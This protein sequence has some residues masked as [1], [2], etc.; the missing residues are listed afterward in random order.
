MSKSAYGYELVI[1]LYGCNAD[2]FNRGALL[3]FFGVICQRL[4]LHPERLH[5]WDYD[6]PIE[7]AAAPAHL[8]GTSAVQFIETSD[9]I[10]HLLDD[11]GQVFINLFSCGALVEDP[12][13][14]AVWCK[15]FFEGEHHTCRVLERGGEHWH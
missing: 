12:E 15:D 9:L 14:I 3:E 4:K 1:D 13:S 8:K 11:L 10:I 7:K 5:W 2:K 6:D